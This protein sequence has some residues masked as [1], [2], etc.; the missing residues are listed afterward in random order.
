MGRWK[1]LVNERECNWEDEH[2]KLFERIT[3]TLCS[4]RREIHAY[5]MNKYNGG[6]KHSEAGTEAY[7]KFMNEFNWDLD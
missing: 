3:R 4:F 1:K 5:F 7:D 2:Y 6:D